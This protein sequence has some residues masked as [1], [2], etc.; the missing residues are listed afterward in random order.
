MAHTT[1]RRELRVP[2]LSDNPDVPR[3]IANLGADID[4]QMAGLQ[5]GTLAARGTSSPK[6]G[7]FWWATDDDSMSPNGSLAKWDEANGVWRN[8]FHPNNPV[9]GVAGART[10]GTGATEAAAGSDKRLLRYGFRVYRSAAFNVADGTQLQFDA[11]D[12]DPDGMYQLSGTNAYSVVIPAA[13]LWRFAA[14]YFVAGSPGSLDIGWWVRFWRN[15]SVD[16][17]DT[18]P[19]AINRG[20]NSPLRS[21]GSAYINLAAGDKVS[22][23]VAVGAAVSATALNVGKAATWFSGDLVRP[24]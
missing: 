3:D 12:Y 18:G 10:L 19:P 15:F 21:Q 17:Y 8:C 22:C 14:Q 1:T 9:A 16:S 13:G 24:A 7:D 11:V 4:T 5:T 23:N 6:D 2:D 20:A